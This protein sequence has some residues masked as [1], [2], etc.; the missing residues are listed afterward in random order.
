MGFPLAS[1]ARRAA[2][3]KSAASSMAAPATSSGKPSSARA[4]APISAASRSVPSPN[5][6]TERIAQDPAAAQQPSRARR[7]G[8][9]QLDQDIVPFRL[10][11]AQLPEKAF[12]IRVLEPGRSPL[13]GQR[14]TGQSGIACQQSGRAP[15]RTKRPEKGSHSQVPTTPVSARVLTSPGVALDAATL[16]LRFTF[17]PP[18]S[19]RQ[20][21][22]N[23]KPGPHRIRFGSLRSLIRPDVI[24]LAT[25]SLCFD[26]PPCNEKGD[27]AAW[28]V[29]FD[30]SPIYSVPFTVRSNGRIDVFYA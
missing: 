26:A 18:R 27:A 22:E 3:S 17:G 15:S 5:G 11:P 14:I 20:E 25:P 16:R 23:R 29:W 19:M 24:S 2:I 21:Y 12:D 4:S 8:S 30:R 1:M 13:A 7:T 10:C 6:S 28:G 9:A